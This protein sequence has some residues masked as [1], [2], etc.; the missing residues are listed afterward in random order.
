MDEPT[1]A[2][3][4]VQHWVAVTDAAGR[5]RLE[6]QWALPSAPTHVPHAA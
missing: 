4:L 2:G 3:G 1:T 6:A 5:T